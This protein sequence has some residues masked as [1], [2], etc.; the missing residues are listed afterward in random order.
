MKYENEMNDWL[1]DLE[2]RTKSLEQDQLITSILLFI[3]IIVT[4]YN[5]I[6]GFNS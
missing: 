1:K 6:K 2:R 3:S 5:L 4:A